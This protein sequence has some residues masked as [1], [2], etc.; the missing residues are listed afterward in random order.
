MGL[1]T[2]FKPNLEKNTGLLTEFSNLTQ[3]SIRVYSEVCKPNSGKDIGL[4]TRFLT[5]I[6]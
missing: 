1:L 3:G 6:T 2:V 5:L 4:L